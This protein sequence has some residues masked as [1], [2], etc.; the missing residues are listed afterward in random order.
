MRAKMSQVDLSR[1][2]LERPQAKQG[3]A[4]IVDDLNLPRQRCNS[5]QDL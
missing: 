2:H 1:Q 5:H 3:H 4:V